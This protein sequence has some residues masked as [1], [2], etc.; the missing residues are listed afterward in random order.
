MYSSHFSALEALVAEYTLDDER[1]WN[2]DE[3]GCSPGKTASNAHHS[4][5]FMRRYATKDAKIV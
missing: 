4:K 5:R 3:T 1:V 2:L